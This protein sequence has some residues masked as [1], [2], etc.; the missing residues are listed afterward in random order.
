M[1]GG[2]RAATHPPDASRRVAPSSSAGSPSPVVSA[3]ARRLLIAAVVVASLASAACSRVPQRAA[4]SVQ[5][6]LSI[7]SVPEAAGLV[8]EIVDT[9]AH[10]RD[11]LSLTVSVAVNEAT[12]AEALTSLLDGS[13][14]A[15]ALTEHSSLPSASWTETEIARQPI[16]VIVH[17]DNPIKN[18]SLDDLGG[19]EAGRITSWAQVGGPEMPILVLSR[20]PGSTARAHVDMATIGA[21]SQLT[22]KLTG[23]AVLLPSDEAMIASV[24]RRPEAI[25]YVTGTDA[26]QGTKIVSIEGI[27]PSAAARGRPYPLW[28]PIFLVSPVAP[29]HSMAALVSYIKGNQ[30]QRLVELWGYGQGEHGR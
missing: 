29:S 2:A 3:T 12:S 11:G 25:G 13:A 17:P 1:I 19:I 23:N 10:T 18:L 26:P 27:Q 24:Q 22:S 5:E 9:F 16:A 20:E 30:G 14:A 15:I 8:G 6:S 7:V 4:S 21:Q 28:Q